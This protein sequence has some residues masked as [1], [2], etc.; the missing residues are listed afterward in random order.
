MTYRNATLDD[1]PV[2]APLN[3]QLIHDEGH[4]N[5]MSVPELEERLRHWLSDEYRATIFED[6]GELVAYALFRQ[7]PG[8]IYLR[9]LFV[10][11]DHRSRGVGR[12]AIELLRSQI[13]PKDKR[14]TVEVLAANTSGIAFWR[15]VGYT[16]Y[17]LTLEILPDGTT[18]A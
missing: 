15:A 16:D 18:C 3:H 1:C 12:R 6:G 9:Q 17:S 11:R 4:R 10:V 13:W 7:H 5:P 2:L 8:E 14:L